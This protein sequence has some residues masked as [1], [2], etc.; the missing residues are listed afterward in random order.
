MSS[1]EVPANQQQYLTFFLA[2]E[3]YAVGVL[4]VKEIIEYGVVTRVPTTPPYTPAKM[5][6]GMLTTWALWKWPL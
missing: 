6:A 4:R 5:S 1:H 2:D 3:Q